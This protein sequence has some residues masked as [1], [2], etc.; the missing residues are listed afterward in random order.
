MP[1]RPS[2]WFT[3]DTIGLFGG[4]EYTTPIKGLS[5]KADFGADRYEAEKAAFNFQAPA[6]WSVGANY[7][8]DIGKLGRIDISLATQGTDRVMARLSLSQNIRQWPSTRS[9]QAKLRPLPQY[10]TTGPAHPKAIRLA[11]DKK[12]IALNNIQQSKAVLSSELSLTPNNSTPAQI[13]RA[14]HAI[15]RAA[16]PHIE[17]I[18]IQPAFLGLRG[19]LISL[20]RTDLENA[21]AHKQG[22]AEEIWHNSSVSPSKDHAFIKRDRRQDIHRGFVPFTLTLDQQLSLSDEDHGALHRTSLVAKAMLPRK[23]GY[24]DYGLAL[25]ANLHDNLHHIQKFR[26]PALLP[27]RSNVEDF[28]DSFISLDEAY[29]LFTHSFTSSLHSTAFAGYLEEMYAGAGGEILYRPH[30]KR[31]ALGTE[32]VLALKRDPNS[33][34][35]MALSGDHVLTAHAKAWYD[36][37]KHDITLS[38]KAGRFL[39]EDIGA[40]IGFIKQ[41][42]NGAQLSGHITLSDT[43]DTDLFGGATHADHSMRLTLPLGGFTYMPDYARL[44]IQH[45]PFGRDIGQSVKL[46]LDLYNATE[47]FTLPH[48]ARHWTEI[49]E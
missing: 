1:V 27:V 25:R 49:T 48:L 18:T 21:S 40:Q 17:D 3:G 38:A 29:S 30:G 23:T 36:I 43:A 24:L 26:A 20:M 31:L 44:S 46:P 12:Q 45:A 39:A 41:F 6:P 47:R 42:K 22:S 10:R 33:T 2:D 14:A 34:L 11:A 7:G 32:S 9:K 37:P 19:P 16:G 28:T 5:L 8:H 13:G 35:D 15:A 4:V